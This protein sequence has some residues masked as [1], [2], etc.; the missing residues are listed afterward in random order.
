MR[1]LLDWLT[2]SGPAA[3]LIVCLVGSWASDACAENPEARFAAMT[4]EQVR[5]YEAEVSEA[6]R[7]GDRSIATLR[8]VV[9]LALIPPKLNTSPLPPYDYDQLDY[10]MTIGIERTR[11]GR[12]W[13]VWVGGEDGPKAFMVAATSDDDGETWSKPRLVID[14]QSPNLPLPRSVIVGTLW[15]D[16]LDR[17]WFFFDQV[18]NHWDGRDGLWAT[19]CED[20]DAESPQWSAAP[21]LAWPR[22]EQAD[23]SLDRRVVV[24]GVSSAS[25]RAAILCRKISSRNS[26]PIAA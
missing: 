4:P 15:T 21:H 14:S 12:L 3:S 23:G 25:V 11:K 6:Y 26:I 13:A 17:L 10:G 7:S 18:M 24:A 9:D 20:P 22:A 19:I 1:T 8:R 5:Q 16:P 2:R